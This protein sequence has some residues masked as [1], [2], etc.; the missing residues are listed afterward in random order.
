MESAGLVVARVSFCPSTCSQDCSVV[1][2]CK[3][4]RALTSKADSASTAPA[5]TRPGRLPSID[6][7][8]VCGRASDRSTPRLPFG[9]PEQVLANLDRYVR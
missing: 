4:W 5:P 3:V 2:S 9:G 1:S 8:T 7:S 6:H